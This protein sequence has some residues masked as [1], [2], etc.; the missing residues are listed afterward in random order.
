[1]VAY[2]V[3]LIGPAGVGKLATAR[4]LAPII[5]AVVV[6]N[7]WINNPIFGLLPNDRVT[8]F[9]EAVWNE[10]A[11]VRSAVLETIAA[12]AP[13]TRSFI[14]TNELY[15]EEIEGRAIV[16][17]VRETA[18]RRGSTY[19]PVRLICTAEELARRIVSPE[20]AARL[21]SMDAQAARANSSRP[22]LSTGMAEELTLDKSLVNAESAAE[23]IATHL[24]SLCT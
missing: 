1:M 18:D 7:Q 11:K 23:T 14:L 10:I 17:Q 5:D 3:H 20:R 15:D 2:I 6:D 4:A 22:V 12:I 21:K 19:I 16:A 8:P 24:R 9:P 13:V